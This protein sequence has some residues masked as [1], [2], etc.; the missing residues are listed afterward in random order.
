M[1]QQN[2]VINKNLQELHSSGYEVSDG[3]PDIRGWKVKASNGE[4]IGKI[5]ELLFDTASLRVRYVI[6][7]LNGK[8]LNLLSRDIIIPVGLAELNTNDKY[9]VFPQVTTAH[10]ASLPEY[11][12][13]EVAVSTER[14]VR[15]VFSPTKAV[16][17][18][19]PDFNDPD[20]YNN[21]YFDEDKMYRSRNVINRDTTDRTE[22]AQDRNIIK[23]ENHSRYI[24][25]RSAKDEFVDD[26]ATYYR[27][28]GP[29]LFEP[30]DDSALERRMDRD[31]RLTDRARKASAA[32]TDNDVHENRIITGRIK[33]KVDVNNLDADD[34]PDD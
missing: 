18:K 2:I 1:A 21:E 9:V 30:V 4:N 15:S 14:E 31:A 24:P 29:N 26:E 28:I 34:L 16:V 33:R 17:Y 7:S 8:P 10:Y 5:K 23:E 3:E 22:T 27:R 13:G 32:A 20:F 19:D 11:K 12:K 6:V 25:V